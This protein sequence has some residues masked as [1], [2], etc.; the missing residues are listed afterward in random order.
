VERRP[1]VIAGVLT[2]LILAILTAETLRE[3]L[4]VPPMPP[5]MECVVKQGGS[6]PDY[7]GPPPPLIAPRPSEIRQLKPEQGR[8][9][10]AKKRAQY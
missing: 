1:L 8:D 6:T 9:K 7:A 3:K 5:E 4:E 10:N 2:A